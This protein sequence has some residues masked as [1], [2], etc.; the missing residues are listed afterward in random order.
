VTSTNHA[1]RW[2]SGALIIVARYLNFFAK[3]TNWLAAALAQR[4]RKVAQ[5]KWH[6]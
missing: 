6:R 2:L 1:E 5:R 4:A 3:A